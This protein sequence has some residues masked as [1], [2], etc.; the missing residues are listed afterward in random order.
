MFFLTQLR[1]ILT[2]IYFQNLFQRSLNS[3]MEFLSPATPLYRAL[4]HTSLF[5][6]NALAAQVS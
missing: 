5:Q 1:E 3:P 4:F 2:G 6:L